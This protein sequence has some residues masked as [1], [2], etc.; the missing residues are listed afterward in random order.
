MHVTLQ[1]NAK[2]SRH[3]ASDISY[4][5]SWFVHEKNDEVQWI[6]IVV[7]I[8]K[9][10]LAHR[11]LHQSPSWFRS[12]LLTRVHLDIRCH[13]MCICMC[14][15]MMFLQLP[16]YRFSDNKDCH[17]L[18]VLFYF[19]PTHRFFDVPEPIFCKTLPQHGMLWNWLCPMG[20][21]ICAP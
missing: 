7:G 3:K 16:A 5:R 10:M 15:V 13:T 8:R 19:V 11:L 21:F 1:R 18:L 14:V 9:Q 12:N 4:L 20:I 6:I 17:I 2:E